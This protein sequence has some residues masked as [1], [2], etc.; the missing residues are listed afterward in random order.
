MSL[1][2]NTST[3]W[4][5][6]TLAQSKN[7]Q[8]KSPRGPVYII[9]NIDDSNSRVNLLE[10]A[11]REHNANPMAEKLPIYEELGNAFNDM[12]KQFSQVIEEHKDDVSSILS[13]LFGRRAP[14]TKDE[15][16]EFAES[17]RTSWAKEATAAYNLVLDQVLP[18]K[19]ITEDQLKN[20]ERVAQ[21]FFTSLTETSLPTEDIRQHCNEYIRK[22]RGL[23]KTNKSFAPDLQ[24]LVDKLL[25][26]RFCA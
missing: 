2:V 21:K 7:I 15:A 1:N 20:V 5:D 10:K 17:C 24:Q 12:S 11:L 8:N 4:V 23:A 6:T 19:K 9:R 18:V 14:K 16:L 3:G 26:I 25:K 13:N 22:I